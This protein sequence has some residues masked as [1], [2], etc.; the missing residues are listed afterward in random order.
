MRRRKDDNLVIFRQFLQTGQ[1]IRSYV[2]TSLRD[3]NVKFTSI[4]SPVGNLIG[5]ITSHGMLVDS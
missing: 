3:Y 2:Y 5:K 1:T 4:S